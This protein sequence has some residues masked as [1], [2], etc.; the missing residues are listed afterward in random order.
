[1]TA[2]GEAQDDPG[3]ASRQSLMKNVFGNYVA[4][5]VFEMGTAEQVDTF[6]ACVLRQVHQLSSHNF[7]C[8]I[9]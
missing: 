7:G 8:R 3:R 9:I 5:S 4:Q 1:M 6:F 2:E